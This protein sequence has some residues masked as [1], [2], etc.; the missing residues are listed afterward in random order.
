MLS[1]SIGTFGI[2]KWKQTFATVAGSERKSERAI[3][4]A[5]EKRDRD[6]IIMDFIQN[7]HRI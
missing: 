7:V 4:K 6:L 1:L 5:N 3:E 2:V